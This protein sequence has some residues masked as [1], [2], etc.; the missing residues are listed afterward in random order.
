MM[1]NVFF[2][3]IIILLCFSLAHGLR[4][5]IAQECYLPPEDTLRYKPEVMKL[6]YEQYLDSLKAF[7]V[8]ANY[9]AAVRKILSSNKEKQIA[10]I[11]ILQETHEPEILPWIATFFQS[12]DQELKAAAYDAL[13]E[14]ITYHAL[15]RRDPEIGEKIIILPPSENDLDLQA[16]AWPLYLALNRPDLYG[17]SVQSSVASSSG[18][19][20]L[21]EFTPLLKRLLNSH[22]PAVQHAAKSAL[23]IISNSKEQQT[24]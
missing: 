20:L 23:E 3:R 8:M 24:N 11:K 16:L 5:Q 2:N 19:L 1:S 15:K 21:E 12:E 9:P 4:A 14:L 22:H 13:E 7:K 17:I 18:Y 10:G 6:Q